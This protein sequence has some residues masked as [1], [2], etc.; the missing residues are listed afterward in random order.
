MK[1]IVTK[2]YDEFKSSDESLS[3]DEILYK[4]YEKVNQGESFD[5][6]RPVIIEA[7]GIDELEY[8]TK[9]VNPE[10]KAYIKE[11]Y[12]PEYA[13]NDQ[14]H[15]ILHILEVIR[16]SFA[17]NDTFKLGLDIN[18]IY[19][20]SSCHDNG[21]Y[22]DHAT[23][24][25]IAA[26]RFF[27]DENMKTFFTDEQRIIIRDAIADHRSSKE[28]EPRTVYGKLIS[29]ADRNTRIDIVFIRSFF[30]AH[31][32]TPEMVIEDYLDYTI[33]RLRKR[34]S[35]ENPEN[36]FFEDDAYRIFLKD[37]RDLLQKDDEFKERYC[38]VN[39][40]SSRSNLVQDED[41]CLEYANSLTR[42]KES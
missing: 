21:K 3:L 34:Y 15:G 7:L 6:L 42:K 12:F 31:E 36:M 39:H 25:K 37:M 23:H 20:I 5:A 26:E 16:R 11:V 22:I 18:M 32:R 35:E 19:A 41:G 4:I 14:G 30:V 24:E 38:L 28:D 8:Y 27:A 1:E 40:I 10:L 17:L 33:N 2:L 9:D 13:K 29:S